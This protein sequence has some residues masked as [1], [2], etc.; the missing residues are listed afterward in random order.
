MGYHLNRL[1]EP[2]YMAGP[3][4]MQTEFGINHRLESCVILFHNHFFSVDGPAA[5]GGGSETPEDSGVLFPL[6]LWN[7]DDEDEESVTG[8][9]I[10]KKSTLD[11]CLLFNFFP[12]FPL[13]LIQAFFR[14]KK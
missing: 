11:F 12:F 5:V 14:K 9:I 4:P 10:E 2:V 1:D 6:D 8:V 7:E 3:K 13:L